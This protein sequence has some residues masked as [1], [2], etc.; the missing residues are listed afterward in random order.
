MKTD[1]E[2]F[3]TIQDLYSLYKTEVELSDLKPLSKKT[4]L[5]N[6]TN[7]IRWINEGFEPGERMK[8]VLPEQQ[9]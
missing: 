2:T 4:Y 1:T 9:T 3:K 8:N 7:F 5:I 6:A